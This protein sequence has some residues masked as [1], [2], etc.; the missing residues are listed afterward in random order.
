MNDQLA[1]IEVIASPDYISNLVTTFRN[2]VLE[3]NI[4][5][6]KAAAILKGMED[7][8]KSLRGDI[9]IRDCVME[10]LDRYPEKVVKYNGVTFTKK[11]VGTRYDYSQCGDPEWMRMKGE[12][13]ILTADMK[14]REAYLKV[15]PPEGVTVI[16]PVTGEV[17][18]IYPP[19]KTCEQG[20]AISYEK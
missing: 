9:L 6:L 18:T 16:N 4:A 17:V 12:Y 19:A 11:I 7:A 20:Y 3:G 8:V 15:L 10:E 5:P 13:D 2:E 1:M 14:R